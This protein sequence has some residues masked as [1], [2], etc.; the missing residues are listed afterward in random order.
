MSSRLLRLNAGVS[1]L[2]IT[3]CYLQRLC[4]FADLHVVHSQWQSQL[5][6]VSSLLQPHLHHKVTAAASELGRAAHGGRSISRL[7]W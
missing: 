1:G 2:H 5:I 3:K 4:S 7:L 6:T